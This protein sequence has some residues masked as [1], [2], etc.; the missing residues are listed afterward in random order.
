MM[1]VFNPLLTYK[2]YTQSGKTVDLGSDP[3]E[4]YRFYEKRPRNGRLLFA[5]TLKEGIKTRRFHSISGL[6]F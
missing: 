5:G 1:G 6:D 2:Q 4:D 3:F